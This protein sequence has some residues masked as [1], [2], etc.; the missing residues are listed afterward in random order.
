M[1]GNRKE[2]APY[3]F[4]EYFSKN[5]ALMVSMDKN[6]EPNV[7]ALSWKTIGQLWAIPVITAAV[8]PSRYTFKL[9]T[10]GI[11][12]FTIN[13]PSHST[14]N[15]FMTTGTSSGRDTDKFKEAGLKTIE[16]NRVKV[17]TIADCL[18]CYECKV[19]HSCKSGNMAQHHLF[20]GEILVSY[21]SIDLLK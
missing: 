5:D 18:L 19:V 1:P 20:F 14:K 12:A 7:M 3:D 21:A 2:I 9:L 6:L 4:I 8:A 11:Q 16:G 15:A 13:I 17:P 10:E